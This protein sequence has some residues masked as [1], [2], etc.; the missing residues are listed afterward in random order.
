MLRGL[1]VVLDVLARSCRDGEVAHVVNVVSI[2]V[3]VV[4][5]VVVKT[6]EVFLRRRCCGFGDVFV[7]CLM[8]SLSWL[9][10][11]SS[12]FPVCQV[13]EIEPGYSREDFALPGRVGFSTEVQYFSCVLSPLARTG[14]C[15]RRAR[16]RSCAQEV[17]LAG[18]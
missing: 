15:C 16:G 14:E 11:F 7:I 9:P 10:S 18:V 12:C 17:R 8:L 6:A 2:A 13:H 1:F 4:V 3:A 5:V